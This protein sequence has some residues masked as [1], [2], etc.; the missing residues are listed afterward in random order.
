MILW[1]TTAHISAVIYDHQ[2]NQHF[3]SINKGNCKAKSQAELTLR[4][5]VVNHIPVYNQVGRLQIIDI[6]TKCI[7][8][9]WN[10]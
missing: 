2:V 6:K 4:R 7:H 3:S 1:I 9:K 8:K 5:D 10:T